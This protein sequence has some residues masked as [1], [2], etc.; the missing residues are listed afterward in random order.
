MLLHLIYHLVGF[1][2]LKNSLLIWLAFVLKTEDAL[3]ELAHQGK[4]I[5]SVLNEV[6]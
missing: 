2:V 6:L 5:F 3:F 4:L 1:D